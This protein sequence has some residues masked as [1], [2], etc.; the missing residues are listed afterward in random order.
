L[1]DALKVIADNN[2]C[3]KCHL[4]GD[5]NPPG[6]ERV[7]GPQLARVYSRLRPEFLR[8]WI[9]NPKRL[10]PYTAM[11]VNIPHDKPVSQELYKGDSVQQLDALVDLLLNFD[12]FME[13][14][15]S[16]KPLVKQPPAAASAAAE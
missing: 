13:S 9:A 8:D 16:I 7:K 14:K 15:T 5:Y 1:G 11:P 3:V 12:Q 2:Y 6:S 10:L 4:V